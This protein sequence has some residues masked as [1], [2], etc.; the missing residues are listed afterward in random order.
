MSTCSRFPKGTVIFWS[1]EGALSDFV[2]PKGVT[3][4]P[5]LSGFITRVI[6]PRSAESGTPTSFATVAIASRAAE[7]R[8]AR[9]A[10]FP[11]AVGVVCFTA[12][13]RSS[14]APST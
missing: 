7:G 3:R 10:I 2:A 4:A 13:R 14:K 1:P 12:S 6:S 11:V 9:G 8:Y 5:G